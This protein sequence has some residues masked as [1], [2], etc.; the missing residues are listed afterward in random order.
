MKVVDQK[1][2][3][4]DE[5]F[6]VNGRTRT[7]YIHDGERF[8]IHEERVP[9]GDESN[10]TILRV[11]NDAGDIKAA[12]TYLN[13]LEDRTSDGYDGHGEALNRFNQYDNVLHAVNEIS[14]GGIDPDMDFAEESN[15]Y[16]ISEVESL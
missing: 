4:L 11:L 9:Q 14:D 13:G 12:A 2:L 3:H 16:D 10:A 1:Y 5:D 6:D 15:E 7:S 8:T